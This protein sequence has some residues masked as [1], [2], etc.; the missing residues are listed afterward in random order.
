MPERVLL[1]FVV[2]AFYGYYILP[3][4]ERAWAYYVTTG[5]AMAALAVVAWPRMRN[6]WGRLACAVCAIESVQQTACGAVEWGAHST[7]QDI[8]KAWLG[9]DWYTVIA[10]MALAAA[11]TWGS[12]WRR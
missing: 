2:A 5:A 9:H 1:G 11:I 7:G 3:E 8:C 4:S 12:T 6:S 10:S